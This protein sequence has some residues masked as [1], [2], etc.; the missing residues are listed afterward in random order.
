MA[1]RPRLL[2][3]YRQC[4][5]FALSKKDKTMKRIFSI[6]A[7]LSLVSAC[8][9]KDKK[10]GQAG[11]SFANDSLKRVERERIMN[12]TANYTT[13]QWLDSTFQNLAK[14]KE[15]AMV[16]VTFR[17]R[18]TGTRPLVVASATASCGCTVPTKPEE[19]IAPGA[20]GTIVAKFDSKGRPGENR[21]S[22]YVDANT[23]PTRNHDL[24]FSVF[25]DKN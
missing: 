13:I 7:V 23:K 11:Q 19:P 8:T 10:A 4:Y 9:L 6:L 1:E 16:E 5:T 17:F 21:K 2:L 24:G 15:G 20:E 14:V 3:S 22:V 12:D 25:V 18:N